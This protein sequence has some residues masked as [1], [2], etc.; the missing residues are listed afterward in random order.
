MG[1][2]NYYRK[3]AE[4]PEYDLEN[5]AQE[6]RIESRHKDPTTSNPVKKDPTTVEE[7]NALIKEYE[8][9]LERMLSVKNALKTDEFD[10]TIETVTNEI[11]RLEE[12]RDK[13]KSNGNFT[14]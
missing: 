3:K 1:L 7:Y 9:C 12:E 8:E 10:T 6:V 13:L 4:I 2:E 14:L 5:R 11:K